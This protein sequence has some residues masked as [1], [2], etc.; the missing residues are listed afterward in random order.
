M[1][2]RG[3]GAW[4]MSDSADL[5]AAAGGTGESCPIEL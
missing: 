5:W 2:Y 4:V 3:A 1:F